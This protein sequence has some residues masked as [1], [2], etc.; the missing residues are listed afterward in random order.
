MGIFSYSRALGV[1]VMACGMVS[2]GP[3]SDLAARTL[4]S[5]GSRK[6]AEPF[7]I[8][9]FRLS[10][11]GLWEKWLG[12]QRKLDD[13]QV[14]LALCDRD[15]KRC[16][17]PAAL[18]FLAI[19]DNAKAREGRAQIGEINRAINLAIHPMSDLAQYG[20]I[21][22]W[23]SPLLTFTTGSGDCEDYAIAKFVAL[24]QA[25]ISPEGLTD[26]D[27]ARHHSWRGSRGCGGAAGRPLAH[28][29]QP[30]HGDGRGRA[31]QE[32]P[33]AV[34]H[35]SIRRHAVRRRTLARGRARPGAVRSAQI[36]CR[37]GLDLIFQL[38]ITMFHSNCLSYIY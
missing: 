6:S 26:R 19:V 15:R 14:Q 27:H 37:A 2:F 34:R 28:T 21:D 36:G 12:V 30:P 17:S 33:T 24:R 18:R 3:A 35:R 23:S 4:L 7:G 31:C 32:L 22:V 25:G 20:E 13:E 5:P 10:G 8:F 1:A 11:G 16:V 38:D 29:R 9:A